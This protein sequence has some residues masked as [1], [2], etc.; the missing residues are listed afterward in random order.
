MIFIELLAILPLKLLDFPDLGLGPV[1]AEDF[2]TVGHYGEEG[3]LVAPD[4]PEPEG[5]VVRARQE[6]VGVVRAPAYAHHPARVQGE[7]RVH[8]RPL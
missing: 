7:V 6:L 3:F 5:G 4:V 2:P 8:Q 1:W